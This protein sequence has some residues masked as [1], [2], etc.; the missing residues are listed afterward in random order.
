MT[1]DISDILQVT[2][3]ECA[4]L[5]VAF[6]LSAGLSAIALRRRHTLVSHARK[7][8]FNPD[9]NTAEYKLPA[10]SVIV[11]AE[12]GTADTLDRAVRAILAQ[13]YPAPFETIVVNADPTGNADI[14]INSLSSEFKDLRTT[15]TPV[16]ARNV[17]IRK[18]AITLGMKAATHD[19][20]LITSSRC[21]AGNRYWLQ[22]MA[23]HFGNGADIVLG[24]VR[25]STPGNGSRFIAFDNVAESA[26]YLAAAIHGHTF[27]GNGMNIGY[28]R[29]LFFS[30][31][32]FSSSL[33]MKYGDDDIF[34]SQIAR[35]A[36]TAVELSPEA[37]VDDLAAES[38]RLYHSVKRHRA[39]TLSHLKSSARSVGHLADCLLWLYTLVTLS[40]TAWLVIPTVLSTE[41]LTIRPLAVAGV[42]AIL[43]VACA[44]SLTCSYRGMAAVLGGRKL[45]LTVPIFCHWKPVSDLQ[46]RLEARHSDNYI[47]KR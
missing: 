5:M 36:T 30:A 6:L 40:T 7:Y 38:A 4:L 12:Y 26:Q 45:R 23:R 3:G 21:V 10:V 39:F 22:A 42:I 28:R 37:A 18:L 31:K 20:V 8:A 46:Y 25:L 27:R 44:V 2:P 15:F 24:N 32:G 13:D 19:F 1:M 16:D 29:D 41:S 34:I 35:N 17:S 43:Y 9:S 14:V 33:D 47:W 11:C